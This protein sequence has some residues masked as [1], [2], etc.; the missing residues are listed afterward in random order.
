M[1]NSF[2]QLFEV[3]EDIQRFVAA[4]PEYQEDF[5]PIAADIEDRRSS[6]QPTII[7]YGVYNAGKS[8]LINALV[9][10]EVAEV[11]DVPTTAQVHEYTWT[12]EHQNYCLTD[13]PGIDAPNVH[14][15][16]TKE[17]LAKADAV[18]FVVNPVGVADELKTLEQVVKLMAAHKKVLMVLNSKE[19][20]P[21]AG[22]DNYI[23]ALKDKLL[24][25]LQKLANE[26]GVSI[27]L[28]DLP[29]IAINALTA[30]KASFMQDPHKQDL[31]YQACNFKQCK[32]SIAQLCKNTQEKEISERLAYRLKSFLEK[33]LENIEAEQQKYGYFDEQ[34]YQNLLHLFDANFE[35]CKTKVAEAITQAGVTMYKEVHSMLLRAAQTHTTPDIT[36]LQHT[37]ES[38]VFSIYKQYTIKANH[39]LETYQIDVGEHFD[40]KSMEILFDGSS[41]GLDADLMQ[42]MKPSPASHEAAL[43]VKRISPEA[44][45][46]TSAAI[47]TAAKVLLPTLG[48]FGS[49]LGRAVPFINVALTAYS[50]FAAFKSTDDEAAARNAQIAEQNRQYEEAYR[51]FEKQV[52]DE[53]R[54]VQYQFEEHLT[55]FFKEQFKSFDEVRKIFTD[56]MEKMGVKN[57]DLTELSV[58]VGALIAK[59]S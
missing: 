57:K 10:K 49:F 12:L 29:I 35:Q 4:H 39:D 8:T 52:S 38:Q 2:S 11:G 54:S 40:G 22:E 50:L 3:Y 43:K 26:Q 18:V 21:Q 13:T 48:T 46:G 30:F 16:V 37:L 24:K 19:P 28:N 32:Q 47:T 41:H 36:T 9:G 25:Q 7:V 34:H 31:L 55:S 15:A 44:L 20:L 14:E 17:K 58:Q 42:A 5:A 56:D 1:V 27:D 59:L 23:P 51:R 33:I 45:A 53:S 6:L